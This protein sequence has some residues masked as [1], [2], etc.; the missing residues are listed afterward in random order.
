LLFSL[1]KDESSY[2]SRYSVLLYVGT[3]LHNQLI[4]LYFLSILPAAGPQ[5][6]NFSQSSLQKRL[7]KKM[8]LFIF[9]F[10]VKII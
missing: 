7:T 3:K 8:K 6:L 2:L 10:L 5:T 1:P 4:L 9:A